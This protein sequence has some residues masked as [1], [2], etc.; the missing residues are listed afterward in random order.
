M[1]KYQ[2]GISLLNEGKVI[3]AYEY[4]VELLKKDP[5]DENALYLKIQIM[6]IMGADKN[7][8]LQ[9]YFKLTKMVKNLTNEVY[10][11]IATIYN[12]LEEYDNA[13]L[14]LITT[15]N[16]IIVYPSLLTFDCN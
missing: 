10:Y 2:K 5:K 4:F 3:E 7:Q 13:I 8:L 9:E 14:F 15:L 1:N 16:G 12:E 6:Q 11:N